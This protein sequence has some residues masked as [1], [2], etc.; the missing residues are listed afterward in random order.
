M[1]E[2][3]YDRKGLPC[4]GNRPDAGVDDWIVHKTDIGIAVRYRLAF[5]TAWST[6]VVPARSTV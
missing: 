6:P 2:W 1:V 3:G 4:D 5:D